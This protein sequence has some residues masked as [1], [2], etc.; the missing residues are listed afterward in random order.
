M[1]LYRLEHRVKARKVDYMVCFRSPLSHKEEFQNSL[2]AF[3]VLLKREPLD[4]S[5]PPVS[6][7]HFCIDYM[8]AAIFSRGKFKHLIL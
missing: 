4:T 5:P 6:T 7:L 1:G 8:S 3:G 2:K